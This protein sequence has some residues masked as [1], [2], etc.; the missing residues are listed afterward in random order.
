MTSGTMTWRGVLVSLGLVAAQAVVAD[1]ADFPSIGIATGV[2]VTSGSYG[3]TAD[4]EDVDVPLVLSVDDE[5]WAVTVRVPYLSVNTTEGNQTSSESGPGDV[6]ASITVFDVLSDWERGLALDMTGAVKF[7]TADPEKALG[8]GE[9]DAT[10][11]LDGYKFFD[12]LTLLGSVGHR[13]RGSTPDTPLKDA[14]LATIGVTFRT[15]TSALF[16]MAFDYRESSLEDT[17]DIQELRAFA[18]LSLGDNWVLECHA[19][20][21][22]T[23]SSADWGGGIAVATQLRR[24]GF[25][26]ADY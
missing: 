4:I 11:Y 24:F 18:S 17:S 8:T 3:G 19:F 20:T 22:F 15:E 6:S 14:F 25:R 26:A 13:W 1:P 7:G 10:L 16:G 23:D 9:N 5:R 21:G 2:N 12:R